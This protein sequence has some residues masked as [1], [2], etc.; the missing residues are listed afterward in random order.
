MDVAPT[1]DMI[2]LKTLDVQLGSYI[3]ASDHHDSSNQQRLS[4][5]V[6]MLENNQMLE[7]ATTRSCP[8]LPAFVQLVSTRFVHQLLSI[9]R[10]CAAKPLLP[11]LFGKQPVIPPRA[12]P[13][14]QPPDLCVS[15]RLLCHQLSPLRV[16]DAKD[17]FG[18]ELLHLLSELCM[19]DSRCLQSLNS[20]GLPSTLIEC[21]YLISSAKQSQLDTMNSERDLFTLTVLPS[22]PSPSEIDAQDSLSL[23]SAALRRRLPQVVEANDQPLSSAS[24]ALSTPPSDHKQLHRSIPDDFVHLETQKQLTALM[25]CL[26]QLTLTLCQHSSTLQVPFLCSCSVQLVHLTFCAGTSAL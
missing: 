19:R 2:R 15:L 7:I 14:S 12:S 25:H 18:L 4:D 11:A 6:D 10:K 26:L 21:A 20:T 9:C 22:V 3:D 1:A 13:S 23:R 5:I 16:F 17:P 8:R 24:S